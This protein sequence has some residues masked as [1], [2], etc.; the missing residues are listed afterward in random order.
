MDPNP[1]ARGSLTLFQA[2]ALERLLP[3]GTP[4][5]HLSRYKAAALIQLHDPDAP[6]RRE[7]ASRRQRKF[8]QLRGLWRAGLTKGEASNLIQKALENQQ[9]QLGTK[10]RPSL[11][12]LRRRA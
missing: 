7:P 2:L 3:E 11:L 8:L 1:R 12:V 5:S 10:E 4:I 6:W 9:S